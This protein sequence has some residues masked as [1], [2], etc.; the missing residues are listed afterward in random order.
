MHPN[1]SMGGVDEWYDDWGNGNE[2][3]PSTAKSSY[4]FVGG[5][6]FNPRE[7]SNVSLV[8][9]VSNIDDNATT[10]LDLESSPLEEE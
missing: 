6:K 8:D 10:A 4:Q 5:G 3:K 9:M 2:A 1:K 7:T